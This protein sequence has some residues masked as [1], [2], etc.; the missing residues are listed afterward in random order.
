M[1]DANICTCDTVGGLGGERECKTFTCILLLASLASGCNEPWNVCAQLRSRIES[2]LKLEWPNLEN[3]F[4]QLNQLSPRLFPQDVLQWSPQQSPHTASLR[5]PTHP[6]GLRM[7]LAHSWNLQCLQTRPW[8]YEERI[9]NQ[10]YVCIHHADACLDLVRDFA[11]PG[12]GQLYRQH[13]ASRL[14]WQSTCNCLFCKPR[15]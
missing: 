12:W 8:A 1:Q 6:E 7:L 3:N 2:S 4:C 10:F 11:P 9:V 14:E 5:A 15:L 13:V